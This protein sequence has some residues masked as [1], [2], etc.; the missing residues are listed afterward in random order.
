VIKT[1]KV[2]RATRTVKVKKL[3]CE[4]LTSK[5]KFTKAGSCAPRDYFTAKG[6]SHWTFSLKLKFGK[7]TYRIWEHAT[8][9]KKYTTKNTAGKFVFF[10][11]S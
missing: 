6:L 9:N 4:F 8:D 7:G 3:E 11:V 5:H 2:R 1:V 10:R